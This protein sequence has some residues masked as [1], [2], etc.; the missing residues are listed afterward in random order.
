MP[1]QVATDS[2]LQISRAFPKGEGQH[3]YLGAIA[4]AV[5]LAVVQF[6]ILIVADSDAACLPF[7]VCRSFLG[8]VVGGQSCVFLEHAAT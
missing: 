4:A 2:L 5:S 3:L 8:S 7:T 6:G 1:P